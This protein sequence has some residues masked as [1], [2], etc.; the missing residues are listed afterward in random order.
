VRPSTQEI[1]LPAASLVAA[2][3]V[4]SGAAEGEAEVVVPADD[5]VVGALASFEPPQPARAAAAAA[6]KRNFAFI[7]SQYT[8]DSIRVPV[9]SPRCG[10]RASSSSEPARWAPGSPR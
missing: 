6:T 5:V 1:R 9:V 2:S 7:Y 10:S 3:N 4:S 8:T